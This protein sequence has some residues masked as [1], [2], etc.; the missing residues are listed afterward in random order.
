MTN[1]RVAAASSE[2]SKLAYSAPVLVTFGDAKEMTRN[3]NQV[4]SGD[5]IFS[6]LAGS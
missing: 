5:S 6:V 2:T 3:I 4:G 1:E